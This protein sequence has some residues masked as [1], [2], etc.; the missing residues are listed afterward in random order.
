MGFLPVRVLI[1]W[2]HTACGDCGGLRGLLP[3]VATILGRLY[4]SNET[5]R[6]LEEELPTFNITGSKNGWTFTAV[7]RFPPARPEA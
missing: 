1:S 6:Q 3:H 5:L 2:C 7:N 4:G